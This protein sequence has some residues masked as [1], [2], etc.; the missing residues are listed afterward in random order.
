[1][2]RMHFFIIALSISI[3]LLSGCTHTHYKTTKI[4]KQDQAQVAIT[5]NKDF[6]NT[7]IST[8]DGKRIEPTC[9]V[10]EKTR[11]SEPSIPLCES[12]F[13][14]KGG[15][16]LYAETYKVVVKKGSVCISIWNGPY[17]YDFCDPPYDLGF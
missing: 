3:L 6:K 16:V 7:V 14:A 13:A 8:N 9:I 1:M 2:K 5:L 4:L 15:E 11:K 10:D 17:R 12:D